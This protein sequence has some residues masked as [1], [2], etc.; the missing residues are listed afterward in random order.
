MR[1]CPAV[2]RTRRADVPRQSAKTSV[3]PKGSRLPAATA[4]RASGC[5]NPSPTYMALSARA[6]DHAAKLLREG[7][8]LTARRVERREFVMPS[9]ANRLAR[10]WRTVVVTDSALH[11]NSMFSAKSRRFDWLGRQEP[12][13]RKSCTSK[14]PDFGQSRVAPVAT[15]YTHWL[16]LVASQ[17][18]CNRASVLRTST[19]PWA[20]PQRVV[21]RC[22]GVNL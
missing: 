16:Q 7:R 18:N 10:T 2:L 12:H 11:R 13:L 1:C 20:L 17:T 3:G 15:G 19:G 14:S 6:A 21:K 22:H 9:G 4:G 5:Q 8:D